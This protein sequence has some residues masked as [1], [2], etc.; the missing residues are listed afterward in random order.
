MILNL[1][2]Q[3][4]NMLFETVRE[5]E[6]SETLLFDL[7]EIYKELTYAN[8]LKE[9]EIELKTKELSLLER[10]LEKQE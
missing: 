8:E 9:K 1:K 7:K 10:L 3:V 6:W 4:N 2:T 5:I